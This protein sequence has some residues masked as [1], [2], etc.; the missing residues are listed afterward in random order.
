MEL[1]EINTDAH[2][3][4]YLYSNPSHL[5]IMIKAVCCNNFLSST[6]SMVK[7]ALLSYFLS[8]IANENAYTVQHLLSLMHD[9][10]MNKNVKK[11]DLLL[12]VNNSW[13][14]LLFRLFKGLFQT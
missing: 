7:V 3:S 5:N 8:N 11:R 6:P 14:L 10:I 9:W 13:K 1:K 12:R 2:S 4:G